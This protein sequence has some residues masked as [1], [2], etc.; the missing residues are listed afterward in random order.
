M[1]TENNNAIGGCAV[2]HYKIMGGFSDVSSYGGSESYQSK[3]DVIDMIYNFVKSMNGNTDKGNV[4]DPA[5]KVKYITDNLR[6]VSTNGKS[7]KTL[8]AVINSKLPGKIDL[9]KDSKNVCSQISNMMGTFTD[10]MKTEHETIKNSYEEQVMYMRNLADVMKG[11]INELEKRISQGRCSFAEKSLIENN[12][13]NISNIQSGISQLASQIASRYDDNFAKYS[14]KVNSYI[15]QDDVA[16]FIDT[17]KSNP[18]DHLNG[19]IINLIKIL[20]PIAIITYYT[21]KALEIAGID[22]KQFYSKH[23]EKSLNELLTNELVKRAANLNTEEGHKFIDAM[24]LLQKTF[25]ALRNYYQRSEIVHGGYFTEDDKFFGD[26]EA[27][28]ESLRPGKQGFLTT[29]QRLE[30]LRKHIQDGKALTT[31]VLGFNLAGLVKDVHKN[32]RYEILEFVRSVN[33]KGTIVDSNANKRFVDAMLALDKELS[34]SGETLISIFTGA[35]ADNRAILDKANINSAL[36]E[37]IEATKNLNLGSAT[38]KIL[39]VI[40]TLNVLIND[41]F[42]KIQNNSY[43]VYGGSEDSDIIYKETFDDFASDL[44][45]YSNVNSLKS[46][47]TQSEGEIVKYSKNQEELNQSIFQNLLRSIDFKIDNFKKELDPNKS[48]NEGDKSE[49][50]TYLMDIRDCILNMYKVGESIDHILSEFHKKI[51]MG[52][53]NQS[54]DNL[55]KL[56]ENVVSIGDW[57]V[58]DRITAINKLFKTTDMLD[59]SP[60]LK[61]SLKAINVTYDMSRISSTIAYNLYKEA[62]TGLNENN[63]NLESLKL[64]RELTKML[65]GIAVQNKINVQ[66]QALV[67]Q[68]LDKDFEAIVNDENFDD[69]GVKIYLQAVFTN[70]RK[71]TSRN[72][73]EL[74]DNG[75]QQEPKGLNLILGGDPFSMDMIFQILLDMVTLRIMYL[76]VGRDLANAASPR[77]KTAPLG[78]VGGVTQDNYRKVTIGRIAYN[79]NADQMRERLVILEQMSKYYLTLPGWQLN[80]SDINYTAESTK[81]SKNMRK[82]SILRNMFL[83]FISIGKTID[84]QLPNDLEIGSMHS[85][86]F[87]YIVTSTFVPEIDAGGKLSFKLRE[88]D[89]SFGSSIHSDIVITGGAG[90]YHEEID[91]IKNNAAFLVNGLISSLYDA[92]HVMYDPAA[93]MVPAGGPPPPAGPPANRGG[94]ND[95]LINDVASMSSFLNL[96][97]VDSVSNNELRFIMYGVL[98]LLNQKV[99]YTDIQTLLNGISTADPANN[100]YS[101]NPNYAQLKKIMV[102]NGAQDNDAYIIKIIGKHTGELMKFIGDANGFVTYAKN[103]NNVLAQYNAANHVIPT[104]KLDG[105]D[106][107]YASNSVR[108]ILEI[109]LKSD[110]SA[111]K[112]KDFINALWHDGRLLENLTKSKLSVSLPGL[113]RRADAFDPETKMVLMPDDDPAIEYKNPLLTVEG[114]VGGGGAGAIAGFGAL[115]QT[116]NQ[117]AVDQQ[118]A[119]GWDVAIN[120]VD[121]ANTAH[122]TVGGIYDQLNQLKKAHEFDM[123]ID[124]DRLREGNVKYD[125]LLDLFE[126]EDDE[127]II[128][129]GGAKRII[130]GT[131]EQLNY[132]AVDVVSYKTDTIIIN[133][134]TG[135]QVVWPTN[136]AL[137]AGT[138]IDD[139]VKDLLDNKKISEI[140]VVQNRGVLDYTDGTGGGSYVTEYVNINAKDYT[141][142][143]ADL[144]TK[145]TKLQDYLVSSKS[146]EF[147][148][149]INDD[150]RKYF[151]ASLLLGG[152]LPFSKINNVMANNRVLVEFKDYD[153]VAALAGARLVA[154]TKKAIIAADDITKYEPT[155]VYSV[156]DLSKCN[157]AG[158]GAVDCSETSRFSRGNLAGN[159]A[160]NVMPTPFTIKESMMNFYTATHYANSLLAHK[161]SKI[162]NTSM[163]KQVVEKSIQMFRIKKINADGTLGNDV[164]FK[165]LDYTQHLLTRAKLQINNNK[166]IDGDEANIR[167]GMT[168]IITSQLAWDN[169]N[170]KNN[171]LNNMVVKNTIFNNTKSISTFVIERNVRNYKNNISQISSDHNNSILVEFLNKTSS[172]I[173]G[174]LCNLVNIKANLGAGFG[175]AGANDKAVIITGTHADLTALHLLKGDGN[176]IARNGDVKNSSLYGHYEELVAD[177]VRAGIAVGEMTTVADIDT[178]LR[179]K[180]ILLVSGMF[181]NMTVFGKEDF[182]VFYSPLTEGGNHYYSNANICIYDEKATVRDSPVEEL[183]YLKPGAQALQYFVSMFMFGY[184]LPLYSHTK[185][186]NEVFMG[187]PN[188]GIFNLFKDNVTQQIYSND[189]FANK[190]NLKGFCEYSNLADIINSM[191]LHNGVDIYQNLL[192]NDPTSAS[193]VSA[194]YTATEHTLYR[195]ISNRIKNT[196][197]I[198][199]GISRLGKGALATILLDNAASAHTVNKVADT[200]SAHQY[201]ASGAVASI[202]AINTNISSTLPR[203]GKPNAAI[204]EITILG[205]YEKLFDIKW[206]EINKGHAGGKAAGGGSAIISD[207]IKGI[208]DILISEASNLYCNYYLDKNAKYFGM[209]GPTAAGTANITD[210]GSIQF[211][212]FAIDSSNIIPLL[213]DIK[214]L[215]ISHN[216][217]TLLRTLKNLS[218][219]AEAQY[220]PYANTISKSNDKN[221]DLINNFNPADLA[222]KYDNTKQNIS[223]IIDNENGL[224]YYN[225]LV[226]INEIADNLKHYLTIFRHK[227]TLNNFNKLYKFTVGY[228]KLSKYLH[229]NK[230]NLLP[231]IRGV[232]MDNGTWTPGIAAKNG[233]EILR[234][235]NVIKSKHNLLRSQK[236][237]VGAGIIETYIDTFA[238][239]GYFYDKIDFQTDNV[240]IEFEDSSLSPLTKAHFLKAI[241]QS[242][243]DQGN[244]ITKAFCKKLLDDLDD[245]DNPANEYKV[246]RCLIF[247]AVL[248]PSYD[249]AYHNLLHDC[250]AKLSSLILDPL[251]KLYIS[252][253]YNIIL[254]PNGKYRDCYA[255]FVGEKLRNTLGFFDI[256]EF[257]TSGNIVK[258]ANTAD[259]YTKG[260]SDIAGLDNALQGLFTEAYVNPKI[261]QT[262]IEVSQPNMEV[263]SE[264]VP[265]KSIEETNEDISER[266]SSIINL[267]NPNDNEVKNILKVG[268]VSAPIVNIPSEAVNNLNPGI[269]DVVSNNPDIAWLYKRLYNRYDHAEFTRKLNTA[270]S[271]LLNNPTKVK[272]LFMYV[273]VN[274]NINSLDYDEAKIKE[275]FSKN[276][277]NIN[278]LE[279]QIQNETGLI[280]GGNRIVG[281]VRINQK[282]AK[283][284]LNDYT[285]AIFNDIKVDSRVKSDVARKQILPSCN[286]V[287]GPNPDA[288]LVTNYNAQIF[289]HILNSGLTI[290]DLLPA[291]DDVYSTTRGAAAICK[292]LEDLDVDY[293]KTAPNRSAALVLGNFGVFLNAGAAA[294][295]RDNLLWFNA[296]A[297]INAIN[298]GVLGALMQLQFN[299]AAAATLTIPNKL[300]NFLN[301][302]N[303]EVTVAA[304]LRVRS[305]CKNLREFINMY[306]I[307]EVKNPQQLKYI[308][309]RNGHKFEELKNGEGAYHAEYYKIVNNVIKF[310]NAK[311]YSKL[312]QLLKSANGTGLLDLAAGNLDDAG[313]IGV[314]SIQYYNDVINRVNN[315]SHLVNNN[316]ILNYLV[317]VAAINAHI[318]GYPALAGPVAA[319]AAGPANLAALR[320]G[321]YEVGIKT[322]ETLIANNDLAGFKAYFAPNTI[323]GG[324]AISGAEAHDAV[325]LSY[326]NSFSDDYVPT[327]VFTYGNR[328]N[329]SFDDPDSMYKMFLIAKYGGNPKVIYGMLFD[330]YTKYDY[331]IGKSKVDLLN[332]AGKYS[333]Y[334]S[335]RYQENAAA[336]KDHKEEINKYRKNIDKAIRNK[337][338]S[339]NFADV[340]A[341]L[342][343]VGNILYMMPIKSIKGNSREVRKYYLRSLGLVGFDM[344]LDSADSRFNGML[345]S[346]KEAQREMLNITNKKLMKPF[347]LRAILRAIDD[348]TYKY[349][350]AGG[351]CKIDANYIRF[352]F[353][354]QLSRTAYLLSNNPATVNERYITNFCK[355]F[356]KA[357]AISKASTVIPS[358][359]K[360]DAGYI[361]N[362]AGGAPYGILAADAQLTVAQLWRSGIG[363]LKDIL[364]QKLFKYMHFYAADGVAAENGAPLLANN[365]GLDFA[366]DNQYPDGLGALYTAVQL[367]NRSHIQ[368]AHPHD[369]AAPLTVEPSV[370]HLLYAF[371]KE[372]TTQQIIVGGGYSN[373]PGA[374]TTLTNNDIKDVVELY[375]LSKTINDKNI[376]EFIK[377]FVDFATRS[378]LT[379][380]INKEELLASLLCRHKRGDINKPNYHIM[381]ERGSIY[382]SN[383]VKRVYQSSLNDFTSSNSLNDALFNTDS[384]FVNIVKAI[385]ARIFEALGLY[386]LYNRKGIYEKDSGRFLTHKT[387]MLIGAGNNDVDPLIADLYVRLPL[388]GLFY[389]DLFEKSGVA[390]YKFGVVPDNTGVF[391]P[392]IEFIFIKLDDNVKSLRHLTNDDVYNVVM[393][394]NNIFSAIKDV[395]KIYKEFIGEINRRYGYMSSRMYDNIKG[396]LR[397]GMRKREYGELSR[398]AR[399]PGY[400][401]NKIRLPGEDNVPRYSSRN[402]NKLYDLFTFADKDKVNISVIRETIENFRRNLD[403]KLTDQIEGNTFKLSPFIN[404]FKSNLINAKGDKVGELKE[405]YNN[406]DH[407]T[408]KA[409]S[410]TEIL[411]T[412]FVRSGI[413]LVEHNMQAI[414]NLFVNSFSIVNFSPRTFD[415]K[416]IETGP[417]GIIYTEMAKLYTSELR[418]SVAANYADFKAGV[419]AKVLDRFDRIF[420]GEGSIKVLAFKTKL[421]AILEAYN[422]NYNV[423]AHKQ[424]AVNSITSALNAELV[425]IDEMPL[426]LFGNQYLPYDKVS[427][428][429][430]DFRIIRNK[431]KDLLD[432]VVTMKS[433]FYNLI[434]TDALNFYD[435][436]ITKLIRL[437]NLTFNDDIEDSITK[438]LN[439]N[440][441]LF[442]LDKHLTSGTFVIHKSLPY[443]VAGKLIKANGANPPIITEES[444]RLIITNFNDL[445]MLTP[446]QMYNTLLCGLL[447]N[448]ADLNGN[449]YYKGLIEAIRSKEVNDALSSPEGSTIDDTLEDP[450]QIFN[451]KNILSR[452]IVDKLNS[453]ISPEKNN[454]FKVLDRPNMNNLFLVLDNMAN[455]SEVTK[456]KMSA[457]LPSYIS[458]FGTLISNA[459]KV[460]DLINANYSGLSENKKELADVILN[461]NAKIIRSARFT[462]DR[463]VLLY[464]ELGSQVNTYM[465]PYDG[466]NEE[467]EQRFHQ[468]HIAPITFM[469]YSNGYTSKKVRE[470]VYETT[471]D[472]ID[473]VYPINNKIKN[474][475]FLNAMKIIYSDNM[476]NPGLFTWD[477][478][479]VAKFNEA[480]PSNIITEEDMM[481]Y[482]RVFIDL[483][484]NQHNMVTSALLQGRNN[485][486][487]NTS[488]DRHPAGNYVDRIK[489]A[490]DI[491]QMLSVLENDDSSGYE[492]LKDLFRFSFKNVPERTKFENQ[493]IIANLIE[494]NI[495]PINLNEMMKEIPL[496]TMF[497]AVY[498]FDKFVERNVDYVLAGK[499]NTDFIEDLKLYL[500]NPLIF[501]KEDSSKFND[502]SLGE[503]HAKLFVDSTPTSSLSITLNY[504]Y[505]IYKLTIIT[506]QQKMRQRISEKNR[507]LKGA[508][509]FAL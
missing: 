11:F 453:L 317:N 35:K 354:L 458:L 262:L 452:F 402:Y 269:K 253:I 120:T 118:V 304:P 275:Y 305:K 3:Q 387:R 36:K 193:L 146:K 444:S 374:F 91:D 143:T 469:L 294:V 202:D 154:P 463:L 395:D 405:F 479:I 139:C 329:A 46:S 473:K 190:T 435:A 418:N 393:L 184:Y 341:L 94:P 325:M 484:K 32:L 208:C 1:S 411:F 201:Y 198:L 312:P 131:I 4:R 339:T 441:S 504:I 276:P 308:V 96:L 175:A 64:Y 79:Y 196:F 319:V 427:N 367:N 27:L 110:F 311:F 457:M 87:Q 211:D 373:L 425:K 41:V 368:H 153:T 233:N 58:D 307:P 161:N 239:K 162:T 447:N 142:N 101:L 306:P 186:A 352:V 324:V 472:N 28:G 109:L 330:E 334:L 218:Q 424:T 232:I 247:L 254:K 345:Y 250:R 462:S 386:D 288:T 89:S 380:F 185:T 214:L 155:G 443:Q 309:E 258:G 347:S 268:N 284:F 248:C 423:D 313:L 81:L 147:K 228:K 82:L 442:N 497:N 156:D 48:L 408:E 86:I 414:Y 137:T 282:K 382:S 426:F 506:I 366:A 364:T 260:V 215:N 98:G 281:G 213:G 17:V 493:S 84:Q 397:E 375:E 230:N 437:F 296:G 257:A 238:C 495:P 460:I 369:A 419:D 220:V 209:Y 273:Y 413:E 358:L 410:P 406:I 295:L 164:D 446:I 261:A 400:K 148:G 15:R 265:E 189:T 490:L 173:Y 492:R 292:D 360:Y 200:F 104:T 177:A 10:N 456:T 404:S 361:E 119:N 207:C 182:S 440:L 138:Q 407:Y 128:I 278:N 204:G 69:V 22:A 394:C 158:G 30:K 183:K 355:T 31:N 2:C 244:A 63:K 485:V 71:Y 19:N 451:A 470:K 335:Q 75:G 503:I 488:E 379:V 290:T 107:N 464:K 241:L 205:S 323:Y 66:Y 350:G 338:N 293:F 144:R 180:D 102:E 221:K 126:Y 326:K 121:L 422:P 417:M 363:S 315:I 85:I 188:S 359:H 480:N 236:Q 212:K 351:Q 461:I 491:D 168:R 365:G 157:P 226:A 73:S 322:I 371:K 362:D 337:V 396:E 433:K 44:K 448:F 421:N 478:M 72:V 37:S 23:T 255:R 40:D 498:N 263:S 303:L 172:K 134:A 129:L 18:E 389:K 197:D 286:Y 235:E 454:A 59:F 403:R 199:F 88:Y 152:V 74:A 78:D 378:N 14:N 500:K 151:Y 141:L 343:G 112:F 68:L 328:K 272:N 246:R 67:D 103:N 203:G 136:G 231:I 299:A 388:L 420:T 336:N 432:Y 169:F 409:L 150:L 51:L 297:A 192:I 431:I 327:P 348:G 108:A 5:K 249:I 127:N 122:H 57:G 287:F 132:N 455:M 242:I 114:I 256:K 149:L 314:H 399:D 252:N 501:D 332:N 21:D 449:F 450:S 50:E 482:I 401:V 302:L 191:F 496:A 65:Y 428:V 194:N 43:K 187:H 125:E 116:L 60:Y 223:E 301:Y 508:E 385:N 316:F 277:K 439:E 310:M 270:A 123:T 471:L 229:D 93:N 321:D 170:A 124:S 477:K 77:H 318:N 459:S 291:Q 502:L 271:L 8:A 24:E 283:E 486:V 97:K 12:I 251:F 430:L 264:W 333:K 353:M 346:Y 25:P 206:T 392:F 55:I 33:K 217:D 259:Y 376:N 115:A 195:Y 26:V 99:A 13:E 216:K 219:T 274:S 445:T 340:V 234:I 76:F 130:G 34:L 487:F 412:E 20:K 434:S 117:E 436:K 83:L 171:E 56:V 505:N 415:P 145:I 6:E 467:Y 39:N 240:Y 163:Q 356:D 222:F 181:L 476:P 106:A 285:L 159:P 280:V 279:R 133:K 70:F 113:L 357:L 47:L 475:K 62:E 167:A 42:P 52:D 165:F 300:V 370:K 7:C 227:T 344:I 416:V 398:D 100:K 474:Y 16:K 61:N 111:G 224:I 289:N 225:H 135:V 54:F 80:N 140:N 9:N 166:I 176:A 45:Y 178:D 245:I 95:V 105:A 160:T 384:L 483:C 298:R 381:G 179:I 390:N 342:N 210:A 481:A 267:E 494:L 507:T 466:F 331:E 465:E 438:K 383:L 174:E 29:Q 509:V 38:S 92:S 372:S 320:P 349:T 429:Q 53:M 377:K 489:A 266:L 468:P 391:G 237:D 243:H 90:K 49:L 499:Y